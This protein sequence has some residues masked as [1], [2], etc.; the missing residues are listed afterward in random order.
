MAWI[1]AHGRPRFPIERAYRETFDYKKQDPEEHANSLMDYI[2]LA[3]YLVPEY[4]KLNSPVLRHP[5]LQPNN[6][7]VSEDLSI[8]GLIDWQHS[9]VLPT[10]LAAG[11]PNSFQNYKDEESMPFFPPQMPRDLESM[12]EDE[13]AIALEQFRRQH[14]HFFYL[15]FTQQMNESHWHALEQETSVLKRRIYHD[16]GSP[17]EGLNTPLQINIVQVVKNW[18]KVAS[19][20]SD[21]SIQKCP[22]LL[23]EEEAQRIT[24]LDESL[25]DFDNE[26]ERINGVLGVASDGWTPNESFESAKERAKLIKEEGLAAVSDDPWLMEMTEK[27][28]PFDDFNEDE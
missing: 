4:P 17:W 14:V 18:S 16:A 1:R 28:W 7:F 15:A 2:R 6:I 19:A 5:D 20:N 23:V 21:G 11:I 27:H 25:R 24:A 26:M 3:P 8:T 13:R 12:E 10:F 9:L 22:V